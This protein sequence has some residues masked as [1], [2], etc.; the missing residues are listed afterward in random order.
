M[1]QGKL[2]K[3]GSGKTFPGSEILLARDSIP[4]IVQIDS[5][6]NH[7]YTVLRQA[8]S[9]VF[10]SDLFLVSRKYEVCEGIQSAQD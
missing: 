7:H 10:I 1:D 4:K 2:F 3:V 6:Y 8:N 5:K 9:L